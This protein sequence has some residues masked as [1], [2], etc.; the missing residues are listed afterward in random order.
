MTGAA[1]WAITRTVRISGRLSV[2]LTAGPAGLCAEWA[3]SLPRRLS[4]AERRRYRAGRDAL[5]AELATRTGL[6]IMVVEV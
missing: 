1:N 2:T 5:L 4:R 3:P 6:R